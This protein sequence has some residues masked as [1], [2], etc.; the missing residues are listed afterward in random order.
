MIRIETKVDVLKDEAQRV[1]AR[2]ADTDNGA[3]NQLGEYLTALEQNVTRLHETFDNGASITRDLRDALASATLIDRYLASNRVT[4]SAQSQWRSLKT[5]FNSL[6]TAN[7]VSWNW[8]QPVTPI[9][10]LPTTASTY[11]AT[12][13]Q[14]RTVLSRIELKTNNYRQQMITALRNDSSADQSDEAIADYLADLETAER[15]LRQR[16]DARQST[17]ADA[18]EVLSRAR[19][20]DQFMTRNRLNAATQAQWRNL[21][22]DFNTL[23][24]YYSVSW[25][26]N[27]TL[28]SDNGGVNGGMNP[29]NFDAR[30]TGT[31]RLNTSLSENT[32]A[33]IDR[34]LSTTSTVERD[35]Y[36]RRLEQRL[37]SP[38]IIAIEKNDSRISLASSILPQVTFQA[39]GV[40]RSET[41]G[42][43]RTVTTT[44]TADE[45][46][47]IINYQG[48]RSSDFYLTFLPMA[49]RRLKVTRRIYLDDGNNSITVSSIYDKTDNVARWNAVN[50]DTNAG[51]GSVTVNDSFVIPNGTRLSAE[52]RSSING[53]QASDRFTMDVTA[54]GQ[55]RGAVIS[56]RVVSEDANSRVQGRSRVL[57]IFDTIRLSG[58]QAY[59]FAGNVD[60]V[61]TAN[62]DMVAVANQSAR[63]ATQPTRNVGGVLG[64]LIGAISGVP[65]DPNAN[66][67]TTA[68]AILAQNRD[69]IDIGSGSQF[70]ITSYATGVVVSPR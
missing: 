25:N 11:T 29:R 34:A 61:T 22:A 45:D 40:A 20:I 44:A 64:A 1:A 47:L 42:R 51:G 8:N 23:A 15:R 53:S 7:R 62:G 9:N 70:Q 31:Y 69:V 13:N 52:L 4:P 38:E 32:T 6:A 59:R 24:N 21:K 54:P 5:D 65:V 2:N 30:L 66:S 41:N 12:D 17:T 36:R 46:G 3:P 60:A 33:A 37:S 67:A 58:G 35:N 49:D 14:V 27:Q 43:G 28:P 68:G 16:F 63:S 55:Y 19:A 57:L 56:G 10:G 48:E 50:V 26:W 18:T 39:D